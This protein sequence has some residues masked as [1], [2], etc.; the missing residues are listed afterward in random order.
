MRSRQRRRAGALATV[1]LATVALALVALAGCAPPV[2]DQDVEVVAE[3]PDW[4]LEVVDGPTLRWEI[5]ASNRSDGG[6]VLDYRGQR[7]LDDATTFLVPAGA[8][9]HVIVAG[10]VVDEAEHVVVTAADGTEHEAELAVAEGWRWYVARIPQ[11]SRMLRLEA[12][13]AQGEV[14]DHAEVRV[15]SAAP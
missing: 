10:P 3:G 1:A 13:D 2:E 11:G 14:V 4:R 8:H 9:H 12:L 7:R 5:V 15:V 6:V